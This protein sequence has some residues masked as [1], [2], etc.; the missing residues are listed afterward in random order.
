MST[1]MSVHTH[2]LPRLL[3][4]GPLASTVPRA[5]GPADV[6]TQVFPFSWLA[7]VISLSCP[8]REWGKLDLRWCGAVFNRTALAS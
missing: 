3:T 1:S 2:V 8:A 5:L 4:L 6:Q 7:V